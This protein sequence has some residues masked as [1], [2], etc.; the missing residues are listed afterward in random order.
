[1]WVIPLPSQNCVPCMCR[2]RKNASC[3]DEGGG[4]AWAWGVCLPGL[5]VPSHSSY[6]KRLGISSVDGVLYAQTRKKCRSSNNVSKEQI[7]YRAGIS[8][9]LSISS[10]A[11]CSSAEQSM[12]A[13]E[14][15]QLPQATKRGSASRQSPIEETAA[16][17]IMS[18]RNARHYCGW[19][20]RTE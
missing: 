8:A 10:N 15:A 9:R 20:R 2:I 3:H 16:R 18:P 17:I 7:R 14:G 1:V 11:D 19:P 6:L 13:A 4:Q 12:Y 5:H